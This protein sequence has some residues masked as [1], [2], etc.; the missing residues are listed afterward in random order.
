MTN[1]KW[2]GLL[3][4]CTLATAC[5]GGSS[6]NAAAG[7]TFTYGAPVAATATETGALDGQLSMAASLQA[8]PDASGAVALADFSGLSDTLLGQGGL[9]RLAS[10][11]VAAR[12][13]GSLAAVPVVDGY[14]NPACVAVTATSVTLTGCSVVVVDLNTTITTVVSGFL[15]VPAPGSLTWD[16]TARVTM[17]SPDLSMTAT[18]HQSGDWTVTDSTIKGAQRAE[19]SLTARAQGQTVSAGMHE[20]LDVDVTYAPGP[21]ACIT[22]GTLEVKRVWTQR[23]QGATAADMPD[24]GA[25]VTWTG[26]G[27]GTVAFS[28]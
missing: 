14:D 2:L 15:K 3:A 27:T 20:S 6:G 12:L 5:G 9:A 1:F 23:P 11:Q 7:R 26:C 13:S 10:P 8:R 4:A 16:L 22:G 21:P 19:I 18:A 24:A 28:Q 17:A 25:L